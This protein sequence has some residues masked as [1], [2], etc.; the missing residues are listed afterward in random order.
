[1]DSTPPSGSS[2]LSPA[3]ASTPPA[4]PQDGSTRAP[5]HAPPKVR[6]ALDHP[7]RTPFVA[8]LAV[9]AAIVL[10]LA[11]GSLATIIVSVVLAMFVALGL[12]PVVL[13]LQRSGR[14]RST[15][16]AIVLAAFMV[17]VAIGVVFVLPA[18][19][20][21]FAEFADALP[22]SLDELTQTSWFLALDP[23]V[24]DAVVA[25]LAEVSAFFAQPGSLL[26][27]FGG[28]LALGV[29][30][31]EAISAG[32]IVVV[33]TIYFLGSLDMMKN[34]LYRLTAA[35]SRSTVETLTER[36][37][38]SV[39]AYVL[40]EVIL[41][42]CNAAVV[43]VLYLVLG[44]PYAAL[45]GVVAFV[46]TLV[47]LIGSVVF[48]VI[49]SLVALLSDPTSAL[50]FA[51]LYLVYMQVEA[52][53]VTPRVMSRAAEIPGVLVILGALIGG[54]L[55]GFLGALV[56]IPVTAAILLIIK[57]V[58]MPLQDSKTLPDN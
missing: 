48:L 42:G 26:L 53:V 12:N 3:P 20:T 52:Y 16:I 6:A 49:G 39:G 34:T 46:V 11:I 33:L 41:A 5:F 54:T 40:G 10:G 14:K 9:M 36:T 4:A 50:I 25:G 29:G 38:D 27:V 35:H 51:A 43:V 44:L 58:A 18:V 22:S 56:A 45:M 55:M 13:A 2:D 31:I 1:M 37:T 24:A 32:V 23:A 30:V 28:A 57:H 7:I 47:P 17:L 19:I 21:E 8:A 15:A